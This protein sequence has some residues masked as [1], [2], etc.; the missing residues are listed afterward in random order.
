MYK[1]ITVLYVNKVAHICAIR[2]TAVKDSHMV[3]C[4]GA[5]ASDEAMDVE[6]PTPTVT[7]DN[8]E[9]EIFRFREK[10]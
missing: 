7:E 5:S 2:S 10:N 3:K 1:S 9:E 4:A 6:V 8:V